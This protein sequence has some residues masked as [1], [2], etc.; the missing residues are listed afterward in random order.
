MRR[1]NESRVSTLELFFD[2]V[3]AFTITPLT[4]LLVRKESW[5]DVWSAKGT[6]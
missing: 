1:M 6:A 4:A 2:P 5:L 3:L